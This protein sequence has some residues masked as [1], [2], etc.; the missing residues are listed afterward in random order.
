L[1]IVINA[2]NLSDSLQPRLC[3]NVKNKDRNLKILHLSGCYEQKNQI[4]LH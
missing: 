1:L 4:D 2:S 3:K